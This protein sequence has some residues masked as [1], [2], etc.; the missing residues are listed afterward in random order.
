MLV[1]GSR[2]F[3]RLRPLD[4][5]RNPVG[6]GRTKRM[7]LRHPPEKE[8]PLPVVDE[9]GLVPGRDLRMASDVAS[10]A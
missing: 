5:G 4:T 1:Y 7:G 6:L 3:N 9:V 2:R 8:P 10:S